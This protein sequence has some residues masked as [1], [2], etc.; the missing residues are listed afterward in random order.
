M[1]DRLEGFIVILDKTLRDDGA[2]C[3]QDAIRMIKGV[4]ATQP[5]VSDPECLC[6]Y[7]RGKRD[8]ELKVI[9][10]L[11]DYPEKETK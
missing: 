4:M 10:A 7:E 1:T 2:E 11:Q 3:V 6:A 8:T 9:K 5:L